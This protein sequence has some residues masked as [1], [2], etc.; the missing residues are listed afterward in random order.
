MSNIT[1]SNLPTGAGEHSALVCVFCGTG[2]KPSEVYC[3]TG[4]ADHL[5]ESDPNFDMTGDGNGTG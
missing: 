3:C 5:M 2:L 1:P 4:C